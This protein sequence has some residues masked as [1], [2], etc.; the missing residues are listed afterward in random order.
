MEIWEILEELMKKAMQDPTLKRELLATKEDKNPVTAF[1]RKCRE[2]GY[3]I[4]L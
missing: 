2:L 1:C 3:E 4:Y